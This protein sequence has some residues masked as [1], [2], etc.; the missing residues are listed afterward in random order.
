MPNSIGCRWHSYWDRTRLAD[1]EDDEMN[2]KELAY[3]K[4]KEWVDKSVMQ[5]DYHV[6]AW[7]VHLIIDSLIDPIIGIDWGSDDVCVKYWY[8]EDGKF[9]AE[10]VTQDDLHLDK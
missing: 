4:L 8:D 5:Y 10:K 6:H 3:W 2:K 7:R 9:Y 1:I